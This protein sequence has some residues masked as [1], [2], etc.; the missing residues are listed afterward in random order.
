MEWLKKSKF[1]L[2]LTLILEWLTHTAAQTPDPPT[3]A[4]G[5]QSWVPGN[6]M[7]R[8]WWSQYSSTTYDWKYHQD[9]TIYND[10]YVRIYDGNAT[11]IDK[12]LEPPYRRCTGSPGEECVFSSALPWKFRLSPQLHRDYLQYYLG[13]SGEE[14]FQAW[15]TD[16]EPTAG[17][18][19]VDV[20][21][22]DMLPYCIDSGLIPRPREG[23]R[24]LPPWDGANIIRASVSAS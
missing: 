20:A 12:D 13:E 8:V 18:S 11:R 19:F 21:N 24:Y 9:I 2:L 16:V 23:G 14:K 4:C 15:H 7:I 10:L 22:K 1:G 17:R 3:S 5:T 6:C